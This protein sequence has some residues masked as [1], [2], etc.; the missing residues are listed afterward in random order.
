MSHTLTRDRNAAQKRELSGGAGAYAAATLVGVMFMGSTLLTPLYGVYRREFGFSIIVL[1]L[2]YSVYVIGNLAALLLLGGLSDQIGRRKVALGSLAVAAV[3]TLIYLFAPNPTWL[4]LARVISGLSIGV[5]SG[6]GTAW[7]AELIGGDRRRASTIATSANFIG[8]AAGPIL[9]GVLAQYAPWPTRLSFVAYFVVVALTAILMARTTETISHTTG[10]PNL[11]PRVGVP[12][13]LRMRFIPPAVSVFGVMA[14][15]GFYAALIPTILSQDLHQKNLA[16]GGAVAAAM[17]LIS[18]IVIVVSRKIAPRTAMLWGLGLMPPAVGLLVLAQAERS[19]VLVLLGALLS[20]SAAAL[21]Y[22]GS[23]QV[24]YEL[25]PADRRAEI[26][27]AYYLCGFAGNALPVIGVGVI[28]AL[29]SALAGS[30]AF[31]VLIAVFALGA[32][33]MELKRKRRAA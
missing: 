22:R 27:S 31:A 17:F 18:A 10:K 7:L 33:V 1:T 19:M 13:E 21:G 16:L 2:L 24:I 32:L 20:G 6:T 3:S 28:T 14:L 12:A 25:A 5:A 8:V 30:A 26:G 15:V 23:L 29:A 9:A 4:F 11:K